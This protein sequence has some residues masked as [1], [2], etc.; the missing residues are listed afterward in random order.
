MGQ[1][2]ELCGGEERTCEDVVSYFGAGR[3]DSRAN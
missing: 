2:S 1:L 3:P